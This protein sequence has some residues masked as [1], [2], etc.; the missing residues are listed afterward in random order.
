VT[1]NTTSFGDRFLVYPMPGEK[2]RL[3]AVEM[4][5]LH[6][7]AVLRL[8]MKTIAPAG[9]VTRAEFDAWLHDLRKNG[10]GVELIAPDQLA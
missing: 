4:S 7:E 3:S 1:E 10:V 5:G 2:L 8:D 6:P 9:N